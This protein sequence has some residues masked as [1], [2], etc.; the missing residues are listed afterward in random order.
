MK[1]IFISL[2]SYI[3]LA[4]FLGLVGLGLVGCH[5]I[6][7]EYQRNLHTATK[8]E[9][10]KWKETEQDLLALKSYIVSGKFAY[11]DGKRGGSA[12]V[13]WHQQQPNYYSIEITPPLGASSVRIVGAPNN[14]SM[15][16]QTGEMAVAKTPEEL[17]Q[18]TINWNFPVSN[19]QYWARGIPAPG[20]APT[21]VL[22]NSKHE[23]AQMQQQGW[24]IDILSFM[25]VQNTSMPE[26]I[27][28]TNG[29]VKV[30]LIF[31]VWDLTKGSRQPAITNPI[32]EKSLDQ[33]TAQSNQ[34]A[35]DKSSSNS[36]NNTELTKDSKENTESKGD[37]QTNVDKKNDNENKNNNERQDEKI[38]KESKNNG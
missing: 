14:I 19:L 34:S 37:D 35:D 18:K 2:F 28:L 9:L 26:R 10:E 4:S 3:V 11:N 13:R 24:T 31:K 17:L 1:R 6:S 33:D 36:N 20:E 16:K 32:D 8:K 38:D 12:D 22:F 25:M 7:T 29:P 23:L 30:K 21:K 5:R 15:M 27:T